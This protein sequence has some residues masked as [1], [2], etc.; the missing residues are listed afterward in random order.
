MLVAVQVGLALVLVVCASLLVKSMWRLYAVDFGFTP[1][2]V[3]SV[4]VDLPAARYEGNQTHFRFFDDV[5]ARVRAIP[6]VSDA[7]GATGEFGVGSG[8]TL[9]FAIDG[10]VSANANG[11]EDPVPLQ[12]VTPGYFETMKIPLLRGRTF[13]ATDRTDGAAVVIINDRLAKRL[14][15][16][17]N[18]IGQRIIFRQGMLPWREIVGIVG[19]TRDDGLDR[20]APPA[21]YLPFA[22]KQANWGWM[23][24][25]TLL[26][27][28]VGDPVEVLPAIRSAVWAIDAELPLIDALPVLAAYAEQLAQR[29]FAMQMLIG[30]A[31]LAMALGAV[32]IY[33]VLACAVAERRREIGI[34]RAL[35]AGAG[36]VVGAVVRSAMIF[37][38]A[39]A[40]AGGITALIA[41]RYLTALLYQVEP[42]DPFTFAA[43]AAML[44]GVAMIAAWLPAR[45]AMQVD[46]METLRE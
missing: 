43:A 14:F 17:G 6:G 18:A 2:H 34:R 4:R 44:L 11:R 35:G 30:S 24:W 45:R 13:A 41:T 25:Q 27:R 28:T 16:D 5:L 21:L 46:P 15:P 29:R 39:G 9:S 19:D 32:G 3:M 23:S 10:R 36:H 38:V 20:D 33:G 7:A 37:A 12:A 8:M 22:Q 26:V 40:V 31:A 42:R 1:E